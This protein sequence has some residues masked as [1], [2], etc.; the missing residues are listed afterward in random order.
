VTLHSRTSI[1]ALRVFCREVFNG[2][3]PTNGVAIHVTIIMVLNIIYPFIRKSD[4]L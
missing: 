2:Q 1:V 3:L 4:E